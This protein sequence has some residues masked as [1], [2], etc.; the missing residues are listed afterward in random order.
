MV[1]KAKQEAIARYNKQNVRRVT[2][3][4]SPL[5][6]DIQEYLET[7]DSMG[8]YLKKLLREDYERQRGS[9]G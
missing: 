3:I 5:D 2:V 7:K 9:E 4:F 6:R 8:G 1:S